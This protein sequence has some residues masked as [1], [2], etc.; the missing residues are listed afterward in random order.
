MKGSLLVIEGLDGSGKAT[1]A[2]ELTAALARMGNRVRKISFP[3]YDNP[4]STL[5][6]L[7]LEG[8]IGTLDTVNVYAASNFYSLDRYITYEQDWKRDYEDGDFVVADRYTTS[9]FCHQMSKLP[10]SEWEGYL[11][12]LEDYEYRLLGLPRPELV[13]FLDMHPLASQ[14]LLSQRYEGDES[15][16]DLHEKNVAYLSR[17]RDAAHYA[18]KVCG[19][20]VIPCND[21]NYQPYPV[22]EIAEAVLQAVL[23]LE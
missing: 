19:W 9:N 20:V 2:A 8:K 17:C 22:E 12:W 21:E 10:Q 1:Q 18:A 6:K 16:K 5:V 4:S 3:N 7:Y 15:K 11:H 23:R 13:L 14:R